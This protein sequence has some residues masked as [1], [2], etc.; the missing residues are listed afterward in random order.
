MKTL[1]KIFRYLLAIC[2]I[3]M[4][5][6]TTYQVIMRY[7][8]NNS[9]SWTEEFVRFIF[10]WVSFIAAALGIQEK[11]HIGIDAVVMH[12]P[13]KI[14]RY[15]QIFVLV[16][17]GS[18][19]IYTGYTAIPVM[20][21]TKTQLSPAMRVPMNYIYLAMLVFGILSVLYASVEIAKTARLIK[22]ENRGVE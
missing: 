13:K 15:I 19:G 6:V 2:M 7:C 21:I 12:L 9:P 5:V 10:V 18:F 8:F 11:I 17:L 4:V 1:T 22:S 20:K 14:Q 16:L 3:L